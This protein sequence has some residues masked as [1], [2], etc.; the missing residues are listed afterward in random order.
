MFC[1][2]FFTLPHDVNL[3]I[4]LLQ[5]HSIL[6]HMERQYFWLK[7]VALGMVEIQED[8]NFD[9]YGQNMWPLSR[10]YYIKF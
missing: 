10:V 6:K 8:C 1:D 9:Q 4:I 2:I 5:T 7:I 3:K